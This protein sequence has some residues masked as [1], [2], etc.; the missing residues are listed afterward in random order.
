[1]EFLGVKP[2]FAWNLQEQSKK[3]KN[4]RGFFILI[5][6]I[7]MHDRLKVYGLRSKIYIAKITQPIYR[8][9]TKGTSEIL[10]GISAAVKVKAVV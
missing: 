9:V 6:K 8:W 5:Y 10:A 3:A 2:C 7:S 4:F 1:M